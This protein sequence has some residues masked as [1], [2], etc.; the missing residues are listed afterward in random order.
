MFIYQRFPF[1]YLV[2]DSGTHPHLEPFSFT[3][4][5]VQFQ[6]PEGT[7][8]DA[9]KWPQRL[10]WESV[11]P[12]GIS[13]RIVELTTEEMFEECASI[14]FRIAGLPQSD[15]YATRLLRQA[16]IT[17]CKTMDFPKTIPKMNGPK[18]K[19]KWMMIFRNFL[20]LEFRA[21]EFWILIYGNLQR[22]HAAWTLL[23]PGTRE[24]IPDDV[25]NLFICFKPF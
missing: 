16:S 9:H 22:R 2:G 13:G 15:A 11:V 8:N 1:I 24:M 18:M 14:E 3:G 7:L 21:F 20:N 10:H 23:S 19:T 4:G 6:Y 17:A 12:Y 25:S 5:A